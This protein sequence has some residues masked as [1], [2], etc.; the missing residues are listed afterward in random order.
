[1]VLSV[2]DVEC[3]EAEEQSDDIAHPGPVFAT[4]DLATG[5]GL[6]AAVRG[7]GTIVYC[8]SNRKGDAAATRNLVR[9]AAQEESPYLVYISIVGVDRFPRGYFKAKL[10]AEGVIAD[11]GLPWTTLRA[12]Q[13]Y[14]LIR[15]GASRLAKLP[16]IPVP[17]G[18]MIQPVDSGEVATRLAELTLG[19][20]RG[21]VPA[22]AG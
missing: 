20:P 2:A 10:E 11:S 18:L 7:V 17:A 12:T 9:A 8:A 14:E 21:R 16:V 22:M 4:G 5:E 3:T 19:E 13:F 15:N 1:M 6:P